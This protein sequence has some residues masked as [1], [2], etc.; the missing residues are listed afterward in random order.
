MLLA[1]RFLQ[2]GTQWIDAATARPVQV[3]LR[4]AGRRREQID[5]AERCGMLAALRHPLLNPLID[6]GVASS[7]SFLDR[8]SVV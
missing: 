2:C 5:W 3:V 4:P 7:S 8:K 1:D 6:F